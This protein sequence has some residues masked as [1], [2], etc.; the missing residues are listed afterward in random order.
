MNQGQ[1]NLAAIWGSSP[2]DIWVVGSDATVHHYD[3]AQWQS[4]SN[5]NLAGHNLTGVWGDN[6]GGIWVSATAGS[7]GAVFKY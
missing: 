3:G 6:N 4:R 5:S 1:R 7:G 2:T